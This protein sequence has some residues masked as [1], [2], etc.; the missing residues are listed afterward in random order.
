MMVPLTFLLDIAGEFLRGPRRE[1]HP[2]TCGVKAPLIKVAGSARPHRAE[3]PA[4]I[5]ELCLQALDIAGRGFSD[6]AGLI[7]GVITPACGLL[8]A[9]IWPVHGWPQWSSKKT[10]RPYSSPHWLH[11]LA[12]MA[13]I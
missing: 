13:T 4:L 6:A 9:G 8:A 10:A 1:Q 3:L 2:A 7:I 12:I 5:A 11:R